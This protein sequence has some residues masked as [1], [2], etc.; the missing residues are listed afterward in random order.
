[1]VP[2]SASEFKKLYRAQALKH[3]P[4][5]GGD[6]EKFKDLVTAKM[7]WNRAGNFK[8]VGSGA[9]AAE[10]P[11]GPV[12]AARASAAPEDKDKPI[13]VSILKKV[14]A[15]KSDPRMTGVA[16]SYVNLN[17]R[18]KAPFPSGSLTDEELD[19]LTRNKEKHHFLKTIVPYFSSLKDHPNGYFIRKK[20]S[21][22]PE[23][24]RST[25]K[26]LEYLLSALKVLW[27]EQKDRE[28]EK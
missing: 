22:G 17:V 19:Y 5:R 23:Q 18:N 1:M 7:G 11:P 12:A 24:F 14:I 8:F 28:K 10:A 13:L 6:E 21:T 9:E 16:M 15:V 25:G 3:H 27:T 4:D 26:S 2:K 20:R